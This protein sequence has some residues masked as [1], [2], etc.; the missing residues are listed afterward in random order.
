MTEPN[1]K[2]KQRQDAVADIFHRNMKAIW[3]QIDLSESQRAGMAT[4]AA[5]VAISHA[6]FFVASVT[7][8]LKNAPMNVQID[9]FLSLVRDAMKADNGPK[10]SLVKNDPT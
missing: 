2:L 7:P 1:D 3:S 9:D 4:L 10:L 5:T 6:A 8:H